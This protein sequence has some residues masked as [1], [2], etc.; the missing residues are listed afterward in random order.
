MENGFSD[1]FYVGIKKLSNYAEGNSR[2]LCFTLLS[3]I[4]DC[5][6]AV[7]AGPG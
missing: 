6:L 5:G 2:D 3:S 4:A 1:F 7:V